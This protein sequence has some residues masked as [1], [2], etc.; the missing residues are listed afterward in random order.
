MTIA[1]ANV[2]VSGD[3]FGQWI[4]KT[5][6]VLDIL[7]NKIITTDSNTAIGN[8]SI[9]GTFTANV[10]FA[11]SY[12]QVGY[13]SQNVVIANTSMTIASDP[14]TN[15]V[16]TSN[17]I[18]ING[19]V[20]YT[21]TLMRMGATNIRDG[22][23]ASISGHFTSNVVVGNTVL[24]PTKIQTDSIN[25]GI[26]SAYT[27]T[28]GDL[29]AN[30]YSD[31]YGLQIYSNPT[32]VLVQNSKMTST[33]LWIQNIHCNVEHVND[34]YVNGK[35]HLGPGG[36]SNLIFTSNVEFMGQN[37]YFATGL[38]SN[39]NIALG[40][41]SNGFTPIAPL[42][43]MKELSIDPLANWNPTYS[44][45]VPSGP[46]NSR[47]SVFME[48]I[49]NNLIEFRNTN[50]LGMHSGIVF[51]TDTQKGYVVFQHQGGSAGVAGVN[52][53][54]GDKMRIG[55]PA[56][57]NFEVR[58]YQTGA[59]DG[60]PFDHSLTPLSVSAGG[61]NVNGAIIFSG[62]NAKTILSTFSTIPSGH[63]VNLVLPNNMGNA[64]Q[65]LSLESPGVMKWADAAT[66]I[67]PLTDLEINSLG[68]GTPASGVRGEIRATND[69][70]AFYS[71]D[72]TLKTNVK[73]IENA[74][75]KIQN[76]NGVTFDWTD[77]HLETHGGEDDYFNRKHD[78][79]VIAQEIEKF[80]PEVVATREDGIKAV[81]YDRIVALLI[82]GIKELKAELDSVKK[83]NIKE[84]KAELDVL[85]KNGCKCGCK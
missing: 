21:G 61:I 14:A 85:K 41:G 24:Y 43:I 58:G 76:I 72:K 75:Y 44:P 3:T 8:S 55:A 57:I 4:D 38:T 7:K 52:G 29:E 26:F 60:A 35:F 18:T 62:T 32:G 84:L 50:Q 34:L 82:E 54:L 23:V 73:N 70:T 74:L 2:N 15:S 51:S 22:N 25:V 30:T 81:K 33:D 10:L 6:R 40:V 79:G 27:S 53:T 37:N 36:S 9:S 71:S 1:I 68:V 49:S 17:G 12:L 20:F 80:L 19:T 47:T 59:P 48:A 46:I 31:R 64:G 83:K 42:H 65:V 39:G 45:S 5:N 56:G 67:T 77:E 16:Y 28:I 69:I 13:T 63:D 66:P 78:I 11:N